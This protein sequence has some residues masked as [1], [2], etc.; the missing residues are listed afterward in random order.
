MNTNRE[1]DYRLYIQ[2]DEEF[3]RTD[4]RQEFSRYETI[5]SGDVEKAK[6][7]YAEVRGNFFEGKGVLSQNPLRNSI[8]HLVVSI[9]VIARMCVEAGLPHSEAYTISDIY[10]QKADV[11]KTVDEVLDL[12]GQAHVDFAERMRKLRKTTGKYS[13][14]VRHAI[15][16]IYDHLHQP[17]KMEELAEKE[18][19]SP[20][21][22]SKLFA[23]EVGTTVKAYILQVKVRT[24]ANMLGNLDYSISDIAYSLGFSSQSAFT[25]AFKQLMGQTPAAYRSG[26]EYIRMT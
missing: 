3:V 13:L 14:Y 24:A 1:L 20:G 4:V 5:V 17:L 6:R 7:N 2:R 16:Y 26:R 9:G 10:I 18:G 12:L 23:K 25:T 15:D 8:Y 11:S 22:F 21:Y 19:L